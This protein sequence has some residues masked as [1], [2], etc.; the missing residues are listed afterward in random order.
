MD[1]SKKY[2]RKSPMTASRVI[3]G[4][5]IVIFMDEGKNRE[6]IIDSIK[7]RDENTYK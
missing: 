3:N 5:A 4:Q 2:P 7:L 1:I 6:I